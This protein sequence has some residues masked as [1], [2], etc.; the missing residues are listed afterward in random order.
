MIPASETTQCDDQCVA[1][2]CRA[3]KKDYMFEG[4][5]EEYYF[6]SKVE[7]NDH[8]YLTEV[9]DDCKVGKMFHIYL[10]HEHDYRRKLLGCVK[11]I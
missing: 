9:V 7:K 5:L 8:P 2:V 6:I 4:C 1:A 3:Q 10:F 11:Y